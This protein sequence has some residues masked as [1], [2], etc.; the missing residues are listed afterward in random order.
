M[1]IGEDKNAALI[2]RSVEML[3]NKLSYPVIAVDGQAVRASRSSS[4]YR[5]YVLKKTSWILTAK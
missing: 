5:P 4:E 3:R 2:E 1:I